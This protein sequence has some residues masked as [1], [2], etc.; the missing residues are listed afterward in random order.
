[1]AMQSSL[2]R[3]KTHRLFNLKL[4]AIFVGHLKIV[5]CHFDCDLFVLSLCGVS[6]GSGVRKIGT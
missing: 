6:F 1:M 4:A 2:A 5:Q 3:E